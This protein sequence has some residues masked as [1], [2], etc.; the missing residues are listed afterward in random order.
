MPTTGGAPAEGS[1]RGNDIASPAYAGPRRVPQSLLVLSFSSTVA[2][3]RLF[4]GRQTFERWA[5]DGI[6]RNRYFRNAYLFR[7]GLVVRRQTYIGQFTV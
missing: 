5:C 4:D 2:V 7:H 1:K 3:R 6:E